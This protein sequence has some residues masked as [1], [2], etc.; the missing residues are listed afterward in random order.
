LCR[1]SG[2][3]GALPLVGIIDIAAERTRLEKEMG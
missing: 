3:V 2:E 1:T